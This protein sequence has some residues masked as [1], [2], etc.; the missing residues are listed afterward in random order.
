MLYIDRQ[1]C[2]EFSGVMMPFITNTEIRINPDEI[3]KYFY[4]ANNYHDKN[5]SFMIPY[6]RL[7]QKN[8]HIQIALLNNENEFNINIFD[9]NN[10]SIDNK[11]SI[12]S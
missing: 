12:N 2:L 7:Q 8:L 11:N 4:F 3:P 1:N 6:D 9:D 10:F 5:F